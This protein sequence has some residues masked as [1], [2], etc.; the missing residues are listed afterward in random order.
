VQLVVNVAMTPDSSKRYVAE[1][2]RVL[3]VDDHDIY[4]LEN[5]VSF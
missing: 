1:V 3:G 4:K 5:A 2:V